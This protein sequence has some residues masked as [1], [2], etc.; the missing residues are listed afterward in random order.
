MLTQNTLQ[1]FR[2]AL[3]TMILIAA[4]GVAPGQ[5]RDPATSETKVNELE[6][7]NMLV[8]GDSI[9]WGQGLR[10][11][12]KFWWRIRN[13]L[14]E[15]TGRRVQERIEAHS[16]AAIEVNNPLESIFTSNNGEVNLLTPTI[17]E[18][19]D[20]ALRHYTDP[21]RV[22]LIL[23]DGCINDVD[24][25]NL[26]D[27]SMS[28]DSLETSIKEKCGTRMQSLLT[29]IVKGF[30]RAHTVVTSYYRIVSPD[31]E[32][33]LFTQLL[34]KKLT[35]LRPSARKMNDRE[36]KERLVANS[37]TWYRVSTASLAQAVAA[38]NSDLRQAGSSQRVFFAEIEFSPEHAFSAPQTLL[39]NFKF[40][41]TNLS[42]LR[43]A[44]VILT[45]GTAAYKPDDDVRQ[46]RSQACKE[47]YKK[48]RDRKETKDEKKRRELG[49]LACRYASLGHPNKMGALIY[50][51]S[52]KGQLQWLISN[53]GWLRKPSTFQPIPAQ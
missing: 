26:L 33:N 47:A 32:S 38:V 10:D 40:A 18:Q 20:R 29:R 23:V 21:S 28:L 30:P 42:G 1:S 15:K 51:E 8:L 13:W 37:E 24:V 22:D 35:S 19:V 2:I 45:L 46:V 48:P 3:A 52:I 25:N 50:T 34:V 12:D 7:L 27:T 53:V 16:G 49:E 9:M 11:R 31:T 41:S 44:I 14:Q 17:N 5:V 4:V 43:K 39:W 36:M 6:T